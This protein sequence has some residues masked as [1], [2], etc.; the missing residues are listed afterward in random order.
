MLRLATRHSA[1][2]PQLPLAAAA[3]ALQESNEWERHA[4]LVHSSSFSLMRY[5]IRPDTIFLVVLVVS[6]P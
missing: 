4:V 3:M 5:F 2:A 6:G 1:V